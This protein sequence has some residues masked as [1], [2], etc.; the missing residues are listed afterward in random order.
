MKTTK[1]NVKLIPAMID[2]PADRFAIWERRLHIDDIFMELALPWNTEASV[3]DIYYEIVN[4]CKVNRVMPRA[5]AWD[6]IDNVLFADDKPVKRVGAKPYTFDDRSDY[7]YDKIMNRQSA[8]M[9]D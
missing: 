1:K 6:V 9:P 5:V 4:Y 2:C 3:E 7:W 8:W